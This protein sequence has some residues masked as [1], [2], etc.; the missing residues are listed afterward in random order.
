MS[1]MKRIDQALASLA[2]EPAISLA[3]VVEA[4]LSDGLPM[5]LRRDDLR[6]LVRLRLDGEPLLE[7][8][9]GAMQIACARVREARLPLPDREELY[10][11]AMS[12]YP[13]ASAQEVED[14]LFAFAEHQQAQAARFAARAALLQVEL[15]RRRAAK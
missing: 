1:L 2:D 11:L 12:A 13:G 3:Q 15:I 8:I 5:A 14:G 9:A 7:G 4:V 10:E 6:L